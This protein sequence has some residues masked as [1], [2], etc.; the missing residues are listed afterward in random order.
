MLLMVLDHALAWAGVAG[1]LGR[2]SITR[3]SLPLFCVVAGALVRP[4]GSRRLRQVGVAGV[5]ATGLGVP[6]GIGQPDVLLLLFAALA[7]A[8]VLIFRGG[9]AVGMAAAVIQPVTWSVPWTGYQPGTV[10]A[11]VLL[12]A[13]VGREAL[14]RAPA[15]GLLAWVG[16]HPLAWYLGHLFVL[17]ALA[18]GRG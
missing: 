4:E 18:V 12:G 13:M 7:I 17:F 3:A 1:G 8:P 14:D 6:I 16:R 9:W 15:V 2:L 10:L 11:L 5:V